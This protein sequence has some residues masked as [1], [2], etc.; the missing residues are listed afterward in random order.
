MLRKT[1]IGFIIG[2][3][4]SFS[5]VAA[6]EDL[7]LTGTITPQSGGSQTLAV[8]ITPN[9]VDLT[10]TAGEEIF[11]DIRFE[12]VGTVRAVVSLASSTDVSFVGLTPTGITT[13]NPFDFNPDDP[14]QA[15]HCRVQFIWEPQGWPSNSKDFYLVGNVAYNWFQPFSGELF[16]LDPGASRDTKLRFQ[17]NK[18]L[19]ASVNVNGTITFTITA[20]Q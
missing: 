19:A 9:P 1:L 6:A 18:H 16:T 10:S 14:D 17:S 12:N 4:L 3:L 7:G 11:R 5:L 15:A 8:V 13:S 20:A 2:L